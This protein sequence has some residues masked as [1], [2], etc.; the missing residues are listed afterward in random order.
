[1]IMIKNGFSRNGTLKNYTEKETEAFKA[2]NQ[3]EKRILNYFLSV[4]WL[5]QLVKE[6]LFRLVCF[7]PL[8]FCLCCY[9]IIFEQVKGKCVGV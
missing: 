1:M 2:S 7:P 6:K 5:F 4:L 3:R 8:R 9:L